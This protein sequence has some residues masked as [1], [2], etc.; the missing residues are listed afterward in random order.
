MAKTILHNYF[1]IL[2]LCVGLSTGCEKEIEVKLPASESKLVIEGRIESDGI[3]KSPPFIT[4]SKTTGYFDATSL[5]DLANLQVHG[6]VITVSVDNI[7]YPLEELCTSNLD[8][9]LLPL[10]AEY[11]GVSKAELAAFNYCVY[12][13]PLADLFSGNFLSGEVGKIYHLKV[14]SEGTTYT[15]STK[16]PSLNTLSDVWYMPAQDDT[17]GYA[18]ANMTDPDTLGDAYRW[19]AKRISHDANGKQKDDNFLAPIGSAFEDKFINGITF[20]FAYDRGHSPGDHDEEFE[21]EI[22][23]FF[24]KAD[25]IVVKFC[26]TDMNVYQFLRLYEIEVNS[27]GS[28]FASPTTIPTNIEGGGLGLWAGY[29]VTYDTIWGEK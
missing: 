7:D 26:T 28:P 18:W 8:T 29:G 10:V 16:I 19:Y 17:F 24:K 5:A 6:A 2:L 1:L 12:T 11:I 4:L 27:A 22:P 20:D 25:T 21:S 13:V 9:S 15:S 3:T 14:V 23:H